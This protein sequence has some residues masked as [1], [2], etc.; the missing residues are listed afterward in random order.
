MYK[1]QYYTDGG[2]IMHLLYDPDIS[3]T[4]PLFIYT[5]V[6]L[7]LTLWLPDTLPYTYHHLITTYRPIVIFDYMNILVGLQRTHLSGTMN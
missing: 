2:Y 7:L 1:R 6:V 3:P 4:S 5:L